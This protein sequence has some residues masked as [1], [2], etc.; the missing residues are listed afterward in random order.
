MPRKPLPRQE[1][2]PSRLYDYRPR[3]VLPL[4]AT[5]ALA[6][7]PGPGSVELGADTWRGLH[8]AELARPTTP[9]LAIPA[10]ASARTVQLTAVPGGV[11]VR[12][13]WVLR[14]LSRGAWFSGQVLGAIPGLRVEHVAWDGAPVATKTTPDGVTVAGRVTG[15]A[16]LELVAFVPGEP[17]RDALQLNLLPAVRGH[18]TVTAPEGLVAVLRAIGPAGPRPAPELLIDVTANAVSPPPD[19]S[20]SPPDATPPTP[21]NE[22]SKTSQPVPPPNDISALPPPEPTDALP[23]RGEFWTAASRLDLSF[24]AAPSSPVS[25]ATVVVARAGLGL[26]VGDA[27]LRGKARLVWEVRQGTIDAVDFTAT[28][29][30]AD[31]DIKGTNVRAVQRSGEGVHVE[32]QAPVAGR[33]ELGLSW[34]VP[35]A[36][37]AE[38]RAP[39][40]QIS[41]NNV[42]RSE[43]AL[44]LARDGE[45]EAVPDLAGW[46]PTTAAALPAWGQGLV[47][48]TPTAAYRAGAGPGGA[49]DLLRFVPIEGPPVVVDVAAYTIA[50][51]RE[52]RA[53]IRAHYEVRNERAATLRVRPP[54]GFEVLGVRV[55]GQTATPARDRE[56]AWRIPLQRSVETVSGLLSFPVE[57]GFLGGA[58]PWDRRERRALPLPQ[59]DAPIAVARTTLH[60]PPGYRSRHKPG[61]GEVVAAF[62]RGDGITYG[63]GVGAVGA[64]EADAVFQSA[65]KNWLANDF[66]AAQADLDKLKQ[67]GASN[68]NIARLQGNLDVI[69]GRGDKDDKGVQ[70][71]IREQ[72]KARSIADQQLQDELRTRAEEARKSGDYEAAQTQYKAAIE[73]GDRLA[74]LEQRE[75]VEQQTTNQSIAFELE[76]TTG[77]LAARKRR[78]KSGKKKQAE[79]PVYRTGKGSSTQAKDEPPPPPAGEDDRDADGIASTVDAGATVTGTTAGAVGHDFADD[80]PTPEDKRLPAGGPVSGHEGAAD[81][82]TG[83]DYTAVLDTGN[84]AANPAPAQTYDAGGQAYGRNEKK[85]VTMTG[86]TSTENQ[87]IVDGATTKSPE[88]PAVT[89]QTAASTP[90]TRT[91]TPISEAVPGTQSSAPGVVAEDVKLSAD[92]ASI[93]VVQRQRFPSVRGRLANA[94]RDTARRARSVFKRSSNPVSSPDKPEPP[95]E[96][97]KQTTDALPEPKVTASAVSVVVPQLGQA[98]LYQRLLLPADAPHTIDVSAR[99]PLIAKD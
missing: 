64:A 34:T 25:R 68:E 71:R 51:S 30:G 3:R 81:V 26:T 8:T 11:M 91:F 28:G 23:I 13:N 52:G 98:V 18:V 9:E 15:T 24:A 57:I 40:P 43:S 77:E 74:K 54:P 2:G 50:T 72:A 75:S 6:L 1:F 38:S 80:I 42:F 19:T 5:L 4:A 88:P 86:T 70:R 84:A 89:Q 92:S 85:P 63:L 32:L 29:T 53:L 12:A 58:D 7:A 22:S 61:D 41:F 56:G 78:V 14:S 31:L 90:V 69:A 93:S 99:E 94:A 65:V 97:E 10:W 48:G 47:E 37:T 76:S 83:R 20:T 87:Y 44:Q 73:V 39:L 96:L 60:L 67:I 49:L 62:T 45:V 79:A 27:E 36:K 59:L 46:T 21:P 35:V 82:P 95:R 55:G 66:D 16:L 33:L 17:T